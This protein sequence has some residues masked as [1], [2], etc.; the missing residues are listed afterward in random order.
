MWHQIRRERPPAKPMPPVS[1]GAGGRSML[2]TRNNAG[3]VRQSSIRFAALACEESGKRYCKALAGNACCPRARHQVEWPFAEQ[4]G[5]QMAH[6]LLRWI[7]RSSQVID[8]QHSHTR[9]RTGDLLITNQL[10]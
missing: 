7:A 5:P 6:I 2:F 4:N 10:H 9:I 1:L 8:Y 3:G